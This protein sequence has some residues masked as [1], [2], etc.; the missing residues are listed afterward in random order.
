M[1][2]DCVLLTQSIFVRGLTKKQYD[3]L[4]DVSLKLNALRNSTVEKTPFV[5]SSDE[6]HYKKINYKSIISNV[7]EEFKEEYSLIQAHLANAAIKKHVDS[8][9]SF[10]ELKNK[11]ID[12]EYDRKV[13]PP[14]EYKFKGK[15]IKRGLYKTHDG[16]II[17]ADVNAA[18]N[19]IR[20]SKQKFNLE[21]LY[22]WERLLQ[23]NSNYNQ[24][25][26]IK[27]NMI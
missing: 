20:K 19:I 11:K 12:G 4:V 10:V 1:S 8:F 27:I 16:K 18:A 24:D 26:Q 2:D 23:V 15:R 13:N 6:K 25:I 9:N 14:M 7:K 17:N 21:R 5:K 3:V 22:K